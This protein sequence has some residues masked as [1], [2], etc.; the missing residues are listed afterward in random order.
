MSSRG[1]GPCDVVFPPQWDALWLPQ[2]KEGEVALM[3]GGQAIPCR[4]DRGQDRSTKREVQA[5]F[6][7]NFIQ[8]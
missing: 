6:K 2:A 5:F 3:C 1:S 7:S 8:R 4:K